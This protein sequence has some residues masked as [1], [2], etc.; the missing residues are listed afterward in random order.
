[1][2]FVGRGALLWR[3]VRAADTA[4]H[5]VDLVCV[6]PDEAVPEGIPVLRTPDVNADAAA[7]TAA[8]SDSLVWSINN[9][10]ILRPPLLGSGLRIYNIHNGPLP[11]YRGRPEVAIAAALLDGETH[12]GATLHEVD[13][14]IDT[15]A[16]LDIELFPIA[17]QDGFAEVMLAGLR[18]CHAVFVRNL[19][20][21]A[22]GTLS[23]M[24]P[25]TQPAGYYGRRQL[26][27]IAARRGSDDFSRAAALG[28]FAPL[29][30]DLAAATAGQPSPDGAAR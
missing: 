19:T 25:S 6:G 22:A 30:P 7:V 29:Y 11:A 3:A 10:T 27:D 14:G 24:P 9:E 16:V 1:M 21:A 15:G 12:Y 2:I 23:P 18:A 17:P 20:A 4:G 5:P 8:C 26:A 13:H 28:V